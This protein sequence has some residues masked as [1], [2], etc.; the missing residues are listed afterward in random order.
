MDNFSCGT[1]V[2]QEKKHVPFSHVIDSSGQICIIPKPEWSGDLGGI[3]LQSP[4]FK[5]T[6]AEVVIICADSCHR[7]TQLRLFLPP[8]RPDLPS[9]DDVLQRWPQPITSIFVPNGAYYP[10]RPAE[11]KLMCSK[12]F[13]MFFLNVTWKQSHLTFE[14]I[15]FL[16]SQNLA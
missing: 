14:W 9:H 11:K 16:L 8:A 7:L 4:Q 1:Q 2:Y 5:V 10:C 12:S 3:P 15:L 13:K 6:S